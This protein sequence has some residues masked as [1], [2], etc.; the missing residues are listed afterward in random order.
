MSTAPT[1]PIQLD[2][3]YAGGALVRLVLSF[4]YAAFVGGVLIGA[5]HRTGHAGTSAAITI[6]A[7]AMASFLVLVPWSRPR[8]SLLPHD[9]KQSVVL[10]RCILI[11]KLALPDRRTIRIDASDL[12]LTVS[13]RR[14][15]RLRST[16]SGRHIAFVRHTADAEA[17]AALVSDTLRSL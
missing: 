3:R 1:G 8:W 13:G 15:D 5:W 11:W 2:E 9:D 10:H 12:P 6:I 4:L 17:L 7:M 14:R 16:G